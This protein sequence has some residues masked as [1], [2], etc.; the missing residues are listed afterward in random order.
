LAF[1]S[2]ATSLTVDASMTDQKNFDM[3]TLLLM[4]VAL[5]TLRRD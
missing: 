3:I 2:F 5:I 4:L 1:L